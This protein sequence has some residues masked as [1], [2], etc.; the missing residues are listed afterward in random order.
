[1]PC[2]VGSFYALQSPQP[3]PNTLREKHQVP[4][5]SH[6]F[7]YQIWQIF[8]DVPYSNAWEESS[9]HIR[10]CLDHNDESPSPIHS[11]CDN[12]HIERSRSN[13]KKMRLKKVLSFSLQSIAI[14]SFVSKKKKCFF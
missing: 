9:H 13:R 6:P 5:T 7:K 4:A 11:K 1:M 2:F 3:H 12:T 14:L 10:A 8:Q